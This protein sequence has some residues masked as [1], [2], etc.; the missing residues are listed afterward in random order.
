MNI[1]INAVLGLCVTAIL[2]GQFPSQAQNNPAGAAANPPSQTQTNSATKKSSGGPFHGKLAAVDLGTQSIRVGKRTF[3]V[4]AETKIQKGG[5]SAK[6]QDGIVGE[7]CSGYVKADERGRL[8]AKS[9][10][11]GPKLS[12]ATA[13]KPKEHTQPQ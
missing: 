9:I 2:L 6:L 12:G 11:F 8:V 3:F 1:R 7:P 13:P 5:K 10:N 4:T